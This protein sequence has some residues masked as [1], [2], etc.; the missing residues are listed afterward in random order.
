MTSNSN[1]ADPD[2]RGLLKAASLLAGAGIAS[3]LLTRAAWAADPVVATTNGKIRGAT[4]DGVHVFKGV[5]Y[6]GDTGGARRFMPTPRAQKWA[7]VQDATQWGRSAPQDAATQEP[8]YAW[9]AQI[10]PVSEDCL[11]VNVYTRGLRDN[12]KRPVMVWFHGGAWGTCAGTAP[13]FNGTSLAR[14]QDVVVVTVNHRLNVFGYVQMDGHD[15]RFAD[16]G[17][18]GVMDMVASLAW[19]R[20]NIGEFGGDPRNVTI[21]GQSGGAAKVIALL[22]MPAAKGLFHK[23]IVESCSGGMRITGREEAAVQAHDL[24]KLLGMESLTGAALQKVPMEALVAAQKKIEDPFRPV[25]DGRS[26]KQDPYYPQAPVWSAHIPLMIGNANT[27]TSYYIRADKNNFAIDMETVKRRLKKFL[28]ADDARVGTLIDVYQSAYPGHDPYGILLMLTTDD[29]FKRN[30][31]KVASL[32]AAAGKAPV[33][34]FNF[35]RETPIE[36]GKIHTPH[37]HEVS[38]IFG[39]TAA[40]AGQVGSG[41]DLERMTRRMQATWASFARSGNPDNATIPQWAPFTDPERQTM[42]LKV[43]SELV[44][45][46][47]G[48]A[49]AA[50]DGMP[51]YEYSIS[52]AEFVKG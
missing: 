50:L 14:N 18:A 6:G 52:R 40:A 47:G 24:A 11:F 49:R 42:V 2:R 29:L 12:K 21:F 33:Y 13:G 51:Y 19:V 22:G 32:H 44:K 5:R 1:P 7:G 31:L 3:S 10:Q 39:T 27:E 28:R 35:A 25:V 43:E 15:P 30:T 34:A 36:D 4:D 48:A 41:D 9:Y 26:F 23:A 37:T 17:C 46:P 20:D 8:F 45:D 38:F 16:A